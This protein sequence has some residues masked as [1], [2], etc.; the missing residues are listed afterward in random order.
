MRGELENQVKVHHD[1]GTLIH[2][3]IFMEM[4]KFRDE[5]FKL[6]KQYLSDAI[7]YNTERA[8]LETNINKVHAHTRACTCNDTMLIDRQAKEKYLRFCKEAEQANLGVDAARS[9]GKSVGEV[10]R[11]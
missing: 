7:R 10:A 6:R 1:R 9:Q 3:D 4:K 8:K 5:Q 11:V 2:K